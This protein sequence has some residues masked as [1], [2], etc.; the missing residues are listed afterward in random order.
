MR[1]GHSTGSPDRDD[2]SDLGEGQPEAPCPADRRQQGE[3]VGI[4]EPVAAVGPRGRREDPR[5]FVEPESLSTEPALGRHLADQERLASHGST[6]HLAL[7]G[8]VKTPSRPVTT[9]TRGSA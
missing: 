2:L 5:G 7:K 9:G 1:T 3:R 4:V 6:L 8:K